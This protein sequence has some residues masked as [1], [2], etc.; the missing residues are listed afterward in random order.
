LAIVVFLGVEDSYRAVVEQAGGSKQRAW[1]TGVARAEQSVRN[2][3]A[4]VKTFCSA[5]EVEAADVESPRAVVPAGGG[6]GVL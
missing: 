5:E 6:I 3:E 1:V 4:T 2:N